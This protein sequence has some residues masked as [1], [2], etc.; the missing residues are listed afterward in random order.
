MAKNIFEDIKFFD[1]WKF[2]YYLFFYIFIFQYWDRGFNARIILQWLRG[3]FIKFRYIVKFSFL[4]FSFAFLL[5]DFFI[6]YEFKYYF[7]GD[8]A[9]I[10]LLEFYS[11]V[12]NSA[13]SARNWYRLITVI[14]IYIYDHYRIKHRVEIICN[15]I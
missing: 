15:R 2:R 14:N 13:F 10:G 9:N 3:Y 7:Y 8:L 11:N 5:L 4:F 1:I 12:I 6:P